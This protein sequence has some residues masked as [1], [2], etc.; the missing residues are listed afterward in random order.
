[1]RAFDVSGIAAALVLAPAV[2]WLFGRLAGRRDWSIGALVVVGLGVGVALQAAILS[3]QC[4]IEGAS[5]TVPKLSFVDLATRRALEAL[6]NP[7]FSLFLLILGV[8][9]AM[10]GWSSTPVLRR[11]DDART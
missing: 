8:F 11:N 2:A 9:V 1:M 5:H 6:A 4:L 10:L 3:V 7:E